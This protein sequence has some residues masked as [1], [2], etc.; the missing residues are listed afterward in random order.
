MIGSLTARFVLADIDVQANVRDVWRAWTTPAGIRSW[1]ADDM[2]GELRA[3]KRVGWVW[4]DLGFTGEYDVLAVDEPRRLSL[5]IARPSAAPDVIDVTM[6]ARG[7]K[8][9][10]VSVKQSG[11]ITP[12]PQ[13]AAESAASGWNMALYLLREAVEKNAGKPHASFMRA[14]KTGLAI[15]QAVPWVLTSGGRAMWLPPEAQGDPLM[16]TTREAIVAWPEVD[17]ILEIKAWPS[18]PHET[19]IALRGHSWS[20]PRSEMEKHA[21]SFD[22]ALAKLDDLAHGKR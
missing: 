18:G 11:F 21:A 1:M 6:G 15:S 7:S 12:N 5:A 19:S 22:K 10:W 17:G 9:T 20:K 13:T 8:E 14:R 3:Q 4:N 16:M 2:V